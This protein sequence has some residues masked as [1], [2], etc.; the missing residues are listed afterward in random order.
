MLVIEFI[1]VYSWQ[2]NQYRSIKL[3]RMLFNYLHLPLNTYQLIF[4]N[5]SYVCKYLCMYVS[6]TIHFLSICSCHRIHT[7]NNRSLFVCIYVWVVSINFI[8]TCHTLLYYAVYVVCRIESLKCCLLF[9][10]RQHTCKFS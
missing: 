5:Y 6:V 1:W 2:S 3:A 8:L 10:P 7:N 4:I 9:S